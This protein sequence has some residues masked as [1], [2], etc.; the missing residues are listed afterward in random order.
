MTLVLPPGTLHAVKTRKGAILIGAEIAV[1]GSLRVMAH[2][3]QPQLEVFETSKTTV[4]KD[5]ESYADVVR[6]TLG[7]R[8]EDSTLQALE[9]RLDLLPTLLK[10][11]NRLPSSDLLSMLKDLIREL[12]NWSGKDTSYM[13]QCVCQ[14]GVMIGGVGAHFKQEHLDCVLNRSKKNG[15]R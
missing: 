12:K 10:T 4:E 14:P 6:L 15:R 2:L 5:I 13:T 1:I 3:I 9:S 7:L 11:L 8:R